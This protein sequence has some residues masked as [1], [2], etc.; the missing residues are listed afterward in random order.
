MRGVEYSV[1]R[2]HTLDPLLAIT[3]AELITPFRIKLNITWKSIPRPEIQLMIN[4]PVL[5]MNLLM[6]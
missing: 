5:L 1:K 2:P 3:P 4:D 6:H